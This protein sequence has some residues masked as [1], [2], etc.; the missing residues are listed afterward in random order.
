MRGVGNKDDSCMEL[1]ADD[2]N[3]AWY[4]LKFAIFIWSGIISVMND[5]LTI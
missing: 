5:V 3:T 2:L 4:Y 1:R